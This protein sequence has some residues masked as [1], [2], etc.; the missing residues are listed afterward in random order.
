MIK[1]KVLVQT[2]DQS[3]KEFPKSEDVT[4]PLLTCGERKITTGNF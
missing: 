1:I 3:K 4:I 2:Y